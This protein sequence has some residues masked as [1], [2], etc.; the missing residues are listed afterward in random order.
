VALHDYAADVLGSKTSVRILRTLA[1][2]EGKVFTVR[3][4]SAASGVSH[5]QASAVV[6]FARAIVLQIRRGN[7]TKLL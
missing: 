6:W 5:P 4:L 7:S 2:Y 1:R 3:E